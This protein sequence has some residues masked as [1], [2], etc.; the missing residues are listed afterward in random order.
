MKSKDFLFAALAASTLS[1]LPLAGSLTVDGWNWTVGDFAVAWVIFALTFFFYRLLTT[2][3]MAGLS[4]KIGAGLAVLA[5]FLIT[6]ITFAVQII[7]DENPGNRLY[8]LAIL[9]GFIGV[10]CS[11]FRAAA[12]A[13]LAFG[14]AA[15]LIAIPAVS[16]LLWP[17]DFNPGYPLIQLLSAGFAALFAASGLFFRHAAGHARE[18]R[19]A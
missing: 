13:K 6:W 5:G 19:R 16:V 9:G 3:P 2:R 14:L 11:R 18:V 8:L 1:L 17:A 12:L 7:G 10:A 15:V 4:Y